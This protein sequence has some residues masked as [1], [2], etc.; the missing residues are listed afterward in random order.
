MKNFTNIITA[1]KNL[2]FSLEVIPPSNILLSLLHH[3]IINWSQRKINIYFLPLHSVKL[4][5]KNPQ[6]I[7]SWLNYYR[8]NSFPAIQKKLW[9]PCLTVM[10]LIVIVMKKCHI[11]GRGVW[12]YAFLN[13]FFF[14]V[15]I[16]HFNMCVC[17]FILHAF[18][19]V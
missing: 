16:L 9:N 14:H 17:M 8:A 18:F 13:W 12:A 19:D 6:E 7:T 10:M 15:F 11:R 2:L 4:F 5:R 1:E 3:T